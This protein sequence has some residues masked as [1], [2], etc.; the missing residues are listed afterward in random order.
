[1]TYMTNPI[2]SATLRKITETKVALLDVEDVLDN[3]YFRFCSD[4]PIAHEETFHDFTI[5]PY[6]VLPAG[7][8]IRMEYLWAHTAKG[9]GPVYDYEVTLPKDATL[10]RVVHVMLSIYWRDMEKQNFAPRFYFIE[11]AVRDEQGRVQIALG[12]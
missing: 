8:T 12:T 5:K 11:D 9:P 3:E 4:D 2:T 7:T 10:Y 6:D 1:M